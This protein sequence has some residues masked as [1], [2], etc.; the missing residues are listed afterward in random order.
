[1]QKTDSFTNLTQNSSNEAE[2]NSKKS[3]PRSKFT[4]NEDAMLKSLVEMHGTSD[5]QYI[6]QLLP[7]RNARQCR[8]RWLYYLSPDVIN[9]PWT[10][11]EENL[12]IEKFEKI[13]PCWRQIAKYFPT[14]TDINIKSHWNLMERRLKKESLQIK[15]DLLNKKFGHQNDTI[16]S[17]TNINNQQIFQQILM[18]MDP[19]D[20]Q[21]HNIQTFMPSKKKRNIDINSISIVPANPSPEINSSPLNFE[22]VSSTNSNKETIKE[23]KILKDDLINESDLW[24][25][26]LM[27]E[28]MFNIDF[29]F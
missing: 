17:I 25:S 3:H 2:R 14:R 29:M 4:S 27:K 5:W 10:Q 23:S 16:S 13:G 19:F 21:M 9:G 1:M 15:K 28:D 26:L 11:E 8:D 12:L 22:P 18:S 6:S 20:F 7:G 24:D